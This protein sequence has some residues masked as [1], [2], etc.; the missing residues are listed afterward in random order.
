MTLRSIPILAVCLA[1]VAAS[2][3]GLNSGMVLHVEEDGHLVLE[4]PRLDHAHAHADG[5][6]HGPHDHDPDADHA[7][8]H[9]LIASSS[10]YPV[11]SQKVERSSSSLT[12]AHLYLSGLDLCVPAAVGDD[13]LLASAE[14]ARGAANH[15]G[16]TA[17]IQIACLRSVVLIV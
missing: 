7:D 3:L 12:V 10:D 9:D 4:A 15:R 6:D 8:L 11:A 13:V 14:A 2:S 1:V 16:G 17:H 5:A